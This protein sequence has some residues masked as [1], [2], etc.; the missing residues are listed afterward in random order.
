M[1]NKYYPSLKNN[2]EVKIFYED[3]QY[4]YFIER[5]QNKVL[6]IYSDIRNGRTRILTVLRRIEGDTEAL[7]KELQK[8]FP[9]TLVTINDNTGHIIIKGDYRHELNDWLTKK[10]F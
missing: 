4:P 9:N 1:P 8:L 2:K 7:H 6:P 5:T 10:G 3:V